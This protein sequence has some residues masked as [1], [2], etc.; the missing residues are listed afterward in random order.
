M[1]ERFRPQFF[2]SGKP[3]A[4]ANDGKTSD[5]GYADCDSQ[6]ALA[7]ILAK[8]FAGRTNIDISKQQVS[9]WKNQPESLPNGVPPP[10]AKVGDRIATNAWVTWYETHMLRHYSSMPVQPVLGGNGGNGGSGSLDDQ[11]RLA[12]KRSEVIDNELKEIQLNVA[13]KEWG[14]VAQFR[15]ARRGALR[16]MDNLMS[17]RWERPEAAQG[18][19]NKAVE[20]GML[21]RRSS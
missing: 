7:G 20:L 1:L 14:P 21:R 16:M 6:A 10:P 3:K 4:S 12:S 15:S 17:R 18:I 2:D 11:A 5:G 19:A 13:K 9:K 8:H